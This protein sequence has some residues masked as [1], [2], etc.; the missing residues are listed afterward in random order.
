[1]FLGYFKI[2]MGIDIEGTF[3]IILILNTNI[4]PKY[5]NS[6]IIIY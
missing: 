2:N 4:V 3:N 1:M 6:S 5:F